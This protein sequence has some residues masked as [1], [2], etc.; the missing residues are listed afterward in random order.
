M[1]FK[2]FSKLW[3]KEISKMYFREKEVLEDRYFCAAI[4]SR[5]YMSV[6]IVNI[7]PP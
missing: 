7:I 6:Q 4:S 3:G 2:K 1:P 5:I